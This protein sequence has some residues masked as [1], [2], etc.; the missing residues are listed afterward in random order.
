M[1]RRRVYAVADRPSYQHLLAERS[2]REHHADDPGLP[3]RRAAIMR[4][5]GERSVFS[6]PLVF[7]DE[8]IGALTLVEKRAPRRFT[9]D[10]LRLLELMAVPAA[11]AVHNARMFRREAEQNRRLAGAAQRQPGDDLHHR[12]RPA[13]GD[14]H[15][16]RRARRSTPPSAPSTPTTRRRRR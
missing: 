11:V 5:W 15:A 13:A 8:V 10:D 14:H 4:R 12:P 2:V 3:R 1:A 16:R 9:P 6:I 7:Q